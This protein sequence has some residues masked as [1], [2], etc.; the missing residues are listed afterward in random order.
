MQAPCCEELQSHARH[1]EELLREEGTRGE[2]EGGEGEEEEEVAVWACAHRAAQSMLLAIQ[3]SSRLERELS[4]EMAKLRQGEDPAMEVDGEGD[5]GGLSELH[6]KMPLAR[7]MSCV[8]R[9][10]DALRSVEVLGV[11]VVLC[12][13]F[14]LCRL[15]SV[16]ACFLCFFFF[17]VFCAGSFSFVVFFCLIVSFHV[18]ACLFLGERECK[19]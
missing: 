17:F 5:T 13:F 1:C 14:L 15:D 7:C 4:Q 10:S 6:L 16:C 8:S 19:T 9:W 2:V 18:F 3:E 12:S 11:I